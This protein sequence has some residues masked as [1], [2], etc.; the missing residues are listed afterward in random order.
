TPSGGASE[1]IADRAETEG[2]VLPEFA[3]QTVAGLR[4]ILPEFAT[5]Q[6]PL[7]VTGY[8]VVDRTLLP[9]ALQ[10]VAADPGIDEVLLLSDL[11]RYTPPDPAESLAYYKAVGELIGQSPRPVVVVSNVLTDVSEF[12]RAIQQ[13]TTY[14]HVV[15][16]IEHGMS[17]LGAAV[18]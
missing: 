1:I 17:A 11:P 8:V 5:V 13:E 4:E 9:R 6:N 18:R 15:G 12:G 10:V 16:G 3:P 2:L 14:P 7:D